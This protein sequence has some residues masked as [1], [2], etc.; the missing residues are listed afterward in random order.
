MLYILNVGVRL[1]FC[2]LYMVSKMLVLARN[3]KII[4]LFF[5]HSISKSIKFKETIALFSFGTIF[6]GNF[7]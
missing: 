7:S 4:I 2:L 6:C 3:A 1:M 5:N